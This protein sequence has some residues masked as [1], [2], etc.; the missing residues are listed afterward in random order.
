MVSPILTVVF[1]DL[2]PPACARLTRQTIRLMAMVA[3]VLKKFIFDLITDQPTE[4]RLNYCCLSVCST[5]YQL[6]R[7]DSNN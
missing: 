1:A 7:Q 5:F 4:N 6:S 3:N 2:S